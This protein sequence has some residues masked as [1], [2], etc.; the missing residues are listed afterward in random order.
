MCLVE[1]AS[2]I[3]TNIT[4]DPTLFMSEHFRPQYVEVEKVTSHPE[5]APVKILSEEMNEE[6]KRLDK[7]NKFIDFYDLKTGRKSNRN[8]SEFEFETTFN[9]I[10][11]QEIRKALKYKPFKKIR[12]LEVLNLKNYDKNLTGMLFG[13]PFAENFYLGGNSSNLFRVEDHLAAV[14]RLWI[15]ANNL[16]SFYLAE[17]SNKALE[18][19]IKGNAGTETV[20]KI[21]LFY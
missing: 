4:I 10:I 8:E 2:R 17:F 19:I 15:H 14:E 5:L 12:K 1:F 6:D 11:D 21:K 9:Y 13:F 16:T 7:I 20:I 18:V 3:P